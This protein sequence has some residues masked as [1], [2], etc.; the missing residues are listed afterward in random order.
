MEL[1]FVIVCLIVFGIG[2]AALVHW[3]IKKPTMVK[4]LTST[5]FVLTYIASI[6]WAFGEFS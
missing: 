4:I 5:I 2:T 1:A 6:I 3:T